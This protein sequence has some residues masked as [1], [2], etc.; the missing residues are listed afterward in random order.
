MK[1]KCGASMKKTGTPCACG[2]TECSKTGPDGWVCDSPYHSQ[3][4]PFTGE[5]WWDDE[6]DWYWGS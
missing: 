3:D 1:C 5:K 4:L 2:N 6:D